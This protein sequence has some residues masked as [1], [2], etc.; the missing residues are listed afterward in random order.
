MVTIWGLIPSH[1]VH[2][3]LQGYPAIK[4][5]KGRFMK[6]LLAIA[7]GGSIGAVA[8]FLIANGIYAWL[9]R[10]FPHG[11]LFINVSGSFL[12]GF[13]SVLMLQRFPLAIEWRAAILI[14]F[15]GAY[16]TFSTFALETLSLFEEGS[17]LKA[18]LNIFLSTVLCL[19]AVWVGLVLARQLFASD[20]YPWMGYGF[21]YRDLGLSFLL[22]FF[23][24]T[25]IEFI[26][27][28]QSL[29]P[30]LRA[31]AFVMLIGLLTMA[32][33]LWLIFKLADLHL[34]F[35]SLLSIFIINALFGVMAVWLAS[36][37]S[38]WLWQANLPR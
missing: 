3:D 18:G 4:P 14:G 26:F 20:F 10:S 9:G 27:L 36:V 5:D 1:G 21:P 16:T 25:L 38:H 15:L 23:L 24:A 19:V 31:M 12:M 29:T 34:E 7:L 6:Q 32:S 35:N 13:L 33:T 28:R 11:T 30:E 22:I 17:L 37:A 2:N 8:R